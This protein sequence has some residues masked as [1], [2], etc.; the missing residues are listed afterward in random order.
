MG[1]EGGGGVEGSKQYNLFSK[2]VRFHCLDLNDHLGVDVGVAHHVA[3]LL[4]SDLPVVVLHIKE[5]L[6]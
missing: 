6:S 2:K 5:K 3:E 4:E 1:E